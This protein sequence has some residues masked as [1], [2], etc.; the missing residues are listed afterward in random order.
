VLATNF[1]SRFTARKSD[2]HNIARPGPR[3]ALAEQGSAAWW[4]I[5]TIEEQE[6]RRCLDPA[7]PA[8]AHHPQAGWLLRGEKRAS[9][10]GYAIGPRWMAAHPPWLVLD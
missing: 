9:A 2:V 5:L 1:S 3:E 4:A 8:L 7:I 10:V 6:T